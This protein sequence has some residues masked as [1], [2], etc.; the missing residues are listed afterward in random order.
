ME[1]SPTTELE[2]TLAGVA[3]FAKLPSASLNAIRRTCSWGRYHPDAT[4]VDYLDASDNVFFVTQGE[5]CVTIYSV[6]G[7]AVS[8]RNLGPGTIFGE[9]AAIDGNPRCA[10]VVAKTDCVIASM[11][12]AAFR[13]LLLTEPAV[14]QALIKELVSN[15]RTLT[16]RVYEFSTLAVNNRIQAE[17]LRLAGLGLR[18]GKGARLEPPPTHAEI[19]SRVST[20]REAVTR[21]LNRLSRIGLIERRPGVLYIKDVD[22]L[23]DMLHEMSGE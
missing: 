16:N 23:A 20:H 17:L 5:V 2:H 11:P 6:S 8:F 22:R 15:I 3:I 18:E 13:K 12:A 7:K 19:A 21:E 1:Q 10:S 9:F 4:I 14:G